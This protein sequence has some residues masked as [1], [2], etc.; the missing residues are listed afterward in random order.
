MTS[1]SDSLANEQQPGEGFAFF[2]WH[3]VAYPGGP[4]KGYA[5]PAYEQTECRRLFRKLNA[6]QAA[7]EVSK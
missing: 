2:R 6:P 1:H 7:L 4:W 5:H 3:T